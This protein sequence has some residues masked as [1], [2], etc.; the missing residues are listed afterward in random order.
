[1][2]KFIIWGTGKVACQCYDEFAK[3]GMLKDNEIICFVDN[4][5]EK[6]G[7]FKGKPVIAPSDIYKYEYDY[8]SIW[9]AKFEKEIKWQI[10]EKLHISSNKVV[11]FLFA[12][13]K[14]LRLKYMYSDDMEIQAILDKIDEK[15][16]LNVYYFEC[17]TNHGGLNQAF[18]DAEADLYYIFFEGKKM[19][20]KRTFEYFKE[21]DGKRYV[22]GD[23]WY[24]QDENS[25]HL[26]EEGDIAVEEG[27]IL[28]DAGVCEGN[29]ALHNIDKVKKVYLIECEE[30]WI[31]ALHY[32][33]LPYRDKVVFCNKFL[34]SSD[35]DKTVCLDTLV[36][37]P[38]NFIKMDIEGEEVNALKGARKTFEKSNF[39]KCAICSYHCHGDEQ[40]IK[41]IL[42]HYGVQTEV[43]KG[44]ML[45]LHDPYVLKNPELRRGIV[46]GIKTI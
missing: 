12:Y 37:E 14:K 36:T 32:T 24:E 41:Q 10:T 20:L 39:I 9:V 27:D 6:L 31:E 11:D 1:M 5:K 7:T 18:Y 35:S 2:S 15:R 4:D 34:S 38:V 17:K 46:R 25:P 40:K 28:V 43:S 45:F 16:I 44:Y 42:E 8:I 33:F 30:E 13:K 29:F 3:M 21:K 23:M 26:Y 22:S 19:Y